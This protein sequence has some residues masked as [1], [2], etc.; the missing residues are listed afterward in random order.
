MYNEAQ[1]ILLH[2]KWISLIPMCLQ[3][4]FDHSLQLGR[5][6]CHGILEPC[7]GH[8]LFLHNGTTYSFIQLKTC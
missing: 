4:L 2:K 8:M 1:N 5:M 3:N 7:A 6:C